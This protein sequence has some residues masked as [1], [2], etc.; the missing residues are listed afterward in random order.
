MKIQQIANELLAL[1][2]QDFDGLNEK[3]CPKFNSLLI[4]KSLTILGQLL[5][6]LTVNYGMPG[7]ENSPTVVLITL[8]M[9]LS[10]NISIMHFHVGVL[11]IYRYLWLINGQLLEL[12]SQ[13]KEDPTITIL[14][15]SCFSG[16]VVLIYFWVVFGVTLRTNLLSL[17]AFPQAFLISVWDFWLSIVL[18][19]LTETT[20]NKTSTILKQFTDLDLKD[21]ELERSLNEFAMLCSHQK[22]HFQFIGMYS[23][24][25]NAGHEM[26]I[27]S[28]SYFICLI[29]FDYMNL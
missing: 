26:V 7:N 8:V 16:N 22:F 24:N 19:D 11:L 29:Q 3:N 18:C 20:G 14:L 27:S 23:F 9:I 10:L 17:V 6:F 2:Y 21:V 15:L 5:S 1:E 13:L 25:Y 12:A 4:Q 28:I